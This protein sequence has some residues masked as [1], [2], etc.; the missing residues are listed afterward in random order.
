MANK[1]INLVDTHA[2][3]D[4][5]AFSND[6]KAV[7]ERAY[8]TGVK[9]IINVG[10][11]LKGSRASVELADKYLHVWASIGLH[12]HDAEADIDLE[13]AIKDL[14]DLAKSSKVVAVG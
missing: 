14:N 9:K 1:K 3:L 10:S 7:I 4:F 2:H 5:E 11:S 6:K 13:M 12:P 8:K